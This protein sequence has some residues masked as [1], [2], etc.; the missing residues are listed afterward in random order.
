[1]LF[2]DEHGAY[3]VVIDWEAVQAHA[4]RQASLIASNSVKVMGW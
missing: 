2:K 3:C 4:D 1:M